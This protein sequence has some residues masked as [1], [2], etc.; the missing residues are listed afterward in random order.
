MGDLEGGQFT[1]QEPTALR[2]EPSTLVVVR[3][4]SVGSTDEPSLPWVVRDGTGMPIE[5]VGLQNPGLVSDLQV[6]QRDHAVVGQCGCHGVV[7]VVQP[8]AQHPR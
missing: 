6:S 2:R 4:G 1:G 3:V 7:A 8:D 5:P